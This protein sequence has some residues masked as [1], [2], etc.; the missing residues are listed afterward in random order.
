[1]APQRPQFTIQVDGGDGES[2]HTV[3][4]WRADSASDHKRG[5]DGLSARQAGAGGPGGFLSVQLMPSSVWPGGIHVEGVGSWRGD[6]WEVA[7]D[8]DLFL[9]ARGGHGGDGGVGEDGQNGGRGRSGEA[10]TRYQE[11]TVSMHFII[12]LFY[13]RIG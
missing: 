11:A 7:A 3:Y 13:P 12:L 2:G 9:S 4:P 10:A 8:H 1:M 5:Q 6:S